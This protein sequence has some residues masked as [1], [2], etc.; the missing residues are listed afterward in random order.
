MKIGKLFVA[1][2]MTMALPLA[3]CDVDQTEEGELPDIEVEDEGNMPEYDVEG[4]D[5][6]VSTDT[7][8]IETPDVDVNMPDE[9]G[10]GEPRTEGGEVY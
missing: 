2:A 10:N 8:T 4:P 9:N 3:A 5:I 6:D 1:L 7:T